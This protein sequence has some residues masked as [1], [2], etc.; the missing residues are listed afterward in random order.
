[1]AW[2]SIIIVFIGLCLFISSCYPELS[3]QQYDK[4]KEDLEKL[5]E[6]RTVLEQEVESLST[7]LAEIK[8]KNTEVRAYIDFLVQLVSTQNSESLLEGEFDTKALVE[9]KEKLLESAEKLKDSEI[10]YYLGLISPENEAQT[11]GIYYKTIES[12]LKAIK[13]ELSVK[14]NGG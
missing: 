14:V 9:S 11:V 6:K 4:L 8:T 5:D 2:K 12:C 3:V 13:Q 7:E 10:E 1:M